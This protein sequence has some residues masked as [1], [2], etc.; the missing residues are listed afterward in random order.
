MNGIFTVAGGPPFTVWS[1]VDN[2]LSGIGLD[3][4]DITG[5]AL[6]AGG[7]TRGQEVAQWFNTAAF[8]TNALGTFGDTGKNFLSGPGFANFDF[9]L[10]KDIPL[11]FGPLAESQRLQF[12]AEFFNLTN[13]PN[14][15]IAPN[16]SSNASGG[17]DTFGS[18]GFG[19]I[20]LAA[21]PRIIQLALKF[22]F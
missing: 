8:T 6:L 16:I 15:M 19:K 1:G 9:S 3:R 12:R 14:L 21:D 20:T 5:N 7:R 18:P 4:A 11:R 2:S 13:H 17:F 22:I 10:L